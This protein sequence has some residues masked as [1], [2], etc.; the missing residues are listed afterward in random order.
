MFR[1]TFT[2]ALLGTRWSARNIT[3]PAE[4]MFDW[5]SKYVPAIENAVS[6]N[7]LATFQFRNTSKIPSSL[8]P[9]NA[10]DAIVSSALVQRV[11]H[12]RCSRHFR[13]KS[14]R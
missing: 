8:N 14:L 3:I 5:T 7:P 2:A 12:E 13:R 10:A 1:L 4:L 6:S 9:A 11:C